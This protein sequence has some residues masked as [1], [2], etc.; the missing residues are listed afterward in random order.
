MGGVG[1]GWFDG[2]MFCHHV[3]H[4][5]VPDVVLQGTGSS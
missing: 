1:L 3:V 2:L 4:L 5:D